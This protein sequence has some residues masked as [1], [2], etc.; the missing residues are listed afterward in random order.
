MYKP[1]TWAWAPSFGQEAPLRGV[2]NLRIGRLIID[3]REPDRVNAKKLKLSHCCPGLACADLSCVVGD[4][5]LTGE[6]NGVVVV[7]VAVVVL[8]LTRPPP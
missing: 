5:L 1:P 7:V 6:F 8:L 4:F 2:G 3:E